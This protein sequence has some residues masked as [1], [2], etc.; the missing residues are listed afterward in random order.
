MYINIPEIPTLKF[1]LL[2]CSP[3]RSWSALTWLE[4]SS[5]V[6]YSEEFIESSLVSDSDRILL[7]ILLVLL[8]VHLNYL[9][10]F[11]CMIRNY[12]RWLQSWRFLVYNFKIWC[13]RLVRGYLHISGRWFF[14]WW[15]IGKEWMNK[16]QY[17]Y[18]CVDVY[19]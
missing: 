3:Y 6:S 12:N 9:K 11:F 18:R 16:I 8:L 5:N 15:T 1:S 10:D 17:M 13:G 2:T 7:L 14:E 19:I 4:T